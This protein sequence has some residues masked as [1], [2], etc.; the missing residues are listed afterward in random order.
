[1]TKPDPFKLAQLAFDDGYDAAKIKAIDVIDRYLHGP[2][3]KHEILYQIKK[4]L[5]RI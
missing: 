4:D 1:M 5:E 3:E 2:Y